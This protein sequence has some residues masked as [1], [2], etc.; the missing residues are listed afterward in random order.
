MHLVQN[1]AD[2]V[3]IVPSAARAWNQGIGPRCMEAPADGG[4][5][6]NMQK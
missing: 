2:R 4:E 3:S 1:S 6:D 5:D